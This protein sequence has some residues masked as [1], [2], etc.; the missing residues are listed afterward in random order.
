MRRF[1]IHEIYIYMCSSYLKD[2]PN[3][4]D[5]LMRILFLIQI[6]SLKTKGKPF[7]RYKTYF[8]GKKVSIAYL[9]DLLEI[10][11]IIVF[12]NDHIYGNRKMKSY[13]KFFKKYIKMS[14]QDIINKINQYID[15]NKAGKYYKISSYTNHNLRRIARL[16]INNE[17]KGIVKVILRKFLGFLALSF[18]MPLIGIVYLFEINFSVGKLSN[19]DLLQIIIVLS[20]LSFIFG[21]IWWLWTWRWM[22]PTE[23]EISKNRN[24][25]K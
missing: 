1:W 18:M 21:A 25:S 12:S 5:Q 10:S 15:N 2:N 9:T 24:E 14:E 20:I 3:K 19:Q 6:N 11:P 4:I 13:L 8:D 16:K 7:Y 17:T 23:Y 22:Q